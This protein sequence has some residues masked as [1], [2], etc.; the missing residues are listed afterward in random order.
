MFRDLRLAAAAR[1]EYMFSYHSERVVQG[2]DYNGWR[3]CGFI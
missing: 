2:V 3:R 1:S